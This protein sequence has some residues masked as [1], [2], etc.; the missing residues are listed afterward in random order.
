[1]A[2]S[3]ILKLAFTIFKVQGGAIFTDKIKSCPH[4]W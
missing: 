1:M 4:L 2:Y 3:D